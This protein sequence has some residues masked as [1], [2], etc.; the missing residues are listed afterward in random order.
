[1][2]GL[3][4]IMVPNVSAADIHWLLAAVLPGQKKIFPSSVNIL[5]IA[6]SVLFPVWWVIFEKSVNPDV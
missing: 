1:M 2:K 3:V 4:C 6:M 5:F